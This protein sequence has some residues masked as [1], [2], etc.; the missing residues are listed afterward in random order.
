MSDKAKLDGGQMTVREA[1]RKG[2]V[3]TSLKYGREFYEAIGKK[4]GKIGGETTKEKYGP[5]FYE[6]IGRKGGQRVKELI[7]RSKRAVRP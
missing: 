7:E 6:T 5:Q 4:G 3:A 1:G 2:G